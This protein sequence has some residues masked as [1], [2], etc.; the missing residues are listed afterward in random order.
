MDGKILRMAMPHSP[1]NSHAPLSGAVPWGRAIPKK[2][3]ATPAS[4]PAST[5]GLPD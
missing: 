1:T 4:P 5:A 2:S 3:H